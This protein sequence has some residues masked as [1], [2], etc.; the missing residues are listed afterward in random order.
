MKVKKVVEQAKELFKIHYNPEYK[1]VF[2]NKDK[3]DIKYSAT[4]WHSFKIGYMLGKGIKVT[5]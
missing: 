2:V 1:D 4:K 5:K 3:V